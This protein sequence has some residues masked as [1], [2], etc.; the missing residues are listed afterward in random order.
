ML[1][2]DVVRAPFRASAASDV[3]ILCMKNGA[4]RAVQLFRQGWR[5]GYKSAKVERVT[6]HKPGVAQQT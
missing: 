6:G 5:D 4:R 2:A 1:L 3:C